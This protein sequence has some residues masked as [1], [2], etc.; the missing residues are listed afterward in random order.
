MTK[1][2]AQLWS[3]NLD[4]VKHLGEHNSEAQKLEH[5]MRRNLEK[6]ETV[7]AE[8]ETA[9]EIMESYADSVCEY[10]TVVTEQAFCDGFCLATKLAAEA[11]S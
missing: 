8:N 9:T 11:L 3:G 1:T 10:L 4:P 5:F 6:L 2:I 7:I